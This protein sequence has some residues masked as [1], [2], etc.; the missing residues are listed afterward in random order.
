MSAFQNAIKARVLNNM[1]IPA[2]DL[3]FMQQPVGRLSGSDRP[4][5][6]RVMFTTSYRKD[7][8]QSLIINDSVDFKPSGNAEI[9]LKI[10]SNSK[11]C[12]KNESSFDLVA[13]GSLATLIEF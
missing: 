13:R 5:P 10:Y 12:T 1:L 3:E 7:L 2:R 9:I 11:L 4:T 8:I 6:H